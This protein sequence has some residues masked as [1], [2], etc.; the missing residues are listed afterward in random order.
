MEFPLAPMTP[1]STPL[2][3]EIKL[4]QKWSGHY[5]FDTPDY[6]LHFR[7][8]IVDKSIQKPGMIFYGADC[9]LAYYNIDV[10]QK[11]DNL[12]THGLLGQTATHHHDSPVD[13]PSSVSVQGEGEIEGTIYDYMVS[14][15]FADDF[16]FNR[17]QL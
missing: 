10:Y 9:E 5:E 6:G 7:R 12:K 2:G 15:L 17:Y 1:E 16:I 3:G 8:H 4:I 11:K 13:I 14:G